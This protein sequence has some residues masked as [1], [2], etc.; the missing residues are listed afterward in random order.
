MKGAMSEIKFSNYLLMHYGSISFLNEGGPWPLKIN[1]DCVHALQNCV[2]AMER[3]VAVI[4][5]LH[6]K[7]S[8]INK[9]LFTVAINN[10]PINVLRRKLW[11][12]NK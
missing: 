5:L 12:S 7:K 1:C 2:S 3:S 8:R 4:I 11:R 10:V 9:G 6:L